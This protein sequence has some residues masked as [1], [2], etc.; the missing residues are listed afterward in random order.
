MRLLRSW[1]ARIPEGR[2]YVVDDLPRLV[3][4]GFDYAALRTSSDDV[5]LLEW[6]IA[7][8]QEDLL[9]FAQRA[10][11]TPDDVLVAPYRLYPEGSGWS[12][13]VWAHRRNYLE[14]VDEG[15]PVCVMFGLGMAYLPRKLLA[16]FA[17]DRLD[18]ASFS[19]WHYANVGKAV[20]IAWD[21]RPVHLNYTPQL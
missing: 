2:S 5:L 10:A 3:I 7:V 11:A 14:W 9:R 20:P 21:V 15:E 8:G 16:A 13:P 19:T 4:D 18:D 17:G 1:P 12:E 6:D